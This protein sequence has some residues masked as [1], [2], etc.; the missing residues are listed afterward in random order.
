MKIFQN[1][2][3]QKP[4]ASVLIIAVFFL[5]ISPIL[6]L[7]RKA[8]ALTG[9]PVYVAG[10]A[11]LKAK[12]IKDSIWQGLDQAFQKGGLTQ[13]IITAGE[14]VSANA[15]KMLEWASGAMLNILL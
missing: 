3:C 13:A 2:L 9:C 10:D 8:Q 4:L 5:L 14:L 11:P 1:N 12:A 6:L 7:P 15:S